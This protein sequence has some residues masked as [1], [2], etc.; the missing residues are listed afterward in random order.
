MAI[1]ANLRCCSAR[2]ISSGGIYPLASRSNISRPI[3]QAV[4]ARFRDPSSRVAR[5]DLLPPYYGDAAGFPG[6]S[7]RQY[8]ALLRSQYG[9]LRQW[10]A[11]DVPVLLL[12]LVLMAD[13]PGRLPHPLRQLADLVAGGVPAVWSLPWI[14]AWRV[15]NP[16]GP[17]NAPKVARR[18]LEDLRAMTEAP[19]SVNANRNEEE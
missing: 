11:G 5:A 15:G 1:A 12:G 9:W 17:A 6:V 7:P 14:E 3:R 18:L 19:V 16:P 10:A 4:F 2:K 8:Q 13:A